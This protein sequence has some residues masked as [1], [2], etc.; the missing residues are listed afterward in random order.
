MG[1]N[2]QIEWTHH[3]FNPWIGCTKVAPG[4]AN[5]YAERDQDFRHSRV[6]WGPQG[7][8]SRTSDAYWKQPIA[9]N[10]EAEQLG[11]RR[12]VFCASLAD[13]FEDW[14]GPISAK[15]G[16]VLHRGE[17]WGRKAGYI[18]LKERIG[19]SVATM[20]DLRSDLFA[21]IDSTPWLDWLLLTK[22]P[23]NI[24]EMWP[25]RFVTGPGGRGE[26]RNR[27]NVWLGASASDQ[28]T[29]IDSC[30]GLRKTAGLAQC[31]FLSLEPLLGP[32]DFRGAL[33]HDSDYAASR[34]IDWI[35]VGG[36][37]GPNARPMHPGCVE[38]VRNQCQAAAIPFFFKQWGEWLPLGETGIYD[39][40]RGEQ[41]EQTGVLNSG[42][43][44]SQVTREA[45]DAEQDLP[46]LMYRVG[47]K[48]AGRLLDGREWNEL[49]EHA[50]TLVEQ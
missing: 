23:E 22:R 40:M 11:Q 46:M 35:I 44:G 43:H 29:F 4:C 5:C 15:N 31:Q 14:Q 7:T 48:K 38:T 41:Y 39:L 21:L 3:T 34:F 18:A 1:A 28:E 27:V 20:N 30:N 9:W 47:K 50:E 16:L 17:A 2:S 36:E 33:W 24:V 10:R 19:K 25:N 12:R 13:V 8:R 26:V 32:I 49:P 42:K 37:S 45:C 6:K